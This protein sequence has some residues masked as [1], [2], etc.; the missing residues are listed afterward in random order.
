MTSVRSNNIS[1]KY[2][3]FTTLGLKDRDYKIRVCSEDSIPLS[4]SILEIQCFSLN[5]FTIDGGMI[6][7]IR[8]QSNVHFTLI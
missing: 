8:F 4:S 5:S 6:E 3:R 2:Q 1:L 7:N